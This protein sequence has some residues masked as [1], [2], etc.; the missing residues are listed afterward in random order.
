MAKNERICR[1]WCFT[2]AGP[3]QGSSGISPGLTPKVAGGR[4]RASAVAGGAGGQ[5]WLC[6]SPPVVDLGA[7]SLVVDGLDGAE[8]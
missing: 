6:G 4:P 7:D 3:G 1:G 5:A 2:S 8:V